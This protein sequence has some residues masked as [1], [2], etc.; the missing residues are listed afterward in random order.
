LANRY[1]SRVIVAQRT[2]KIEI[3]VAIILT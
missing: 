2:I 3:V 1:P